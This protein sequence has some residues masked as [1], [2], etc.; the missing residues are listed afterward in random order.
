MPTVSDVTTVKYSGDLRAD[1]LLDEMPDWNYLLPTRTTLF[2]TF[3]VTAMQTVTATAM[4]A[5]NATQRSAATAILNYVT[6]LTGIAFTLT[7]N[8]SAAD[9]HFGSNNLAGATTSGLTRTTESYSFTSGNLLTSYTAE[10]FIYLDN[11]EFAAANN[12]PLAGSQGY[13]VL[14][15]EVGH[16]LGLGHPFDAQFKLSAAEDNT[17]N[18]VMSY[19]AAGGIK[20]TFQSYDVL[21]LQ[22]IYGADGLQGTSGFNSANG[23]S[24]TGGVDALTVTSFSPADEATGVSVGSNILLTFNR[25]IVRGTGSIVL[26]TAAG[27]VVETFDAATS[28]RLSLSGKVLT[29]N[30]TLDLTNSVQYKLEFAAGTIKDASSTS[31]AGTTSY[32]FTA[33]AADV[34]VVDTTAPSISSFTPAVGGTEVATSS[35]ID[36][37]FSESVVKGTGT[38]TL[39]G[40]NGVVVESFDVATS[41]QVTLVGQTLTIDPTA[42]LSRN[43]VYTVE[44]PAGVVRDAAGNVSTAKSGYTFTTVVGD[45]TPPQ[46]LTFSPANA[47]KEVEVFRNIEIGF[48]EAIARGVGTVTLKTSAGA[49]VETFDAATSSRLTIVDSVI[50]ID[51]SADLARNASYTVEI[52]SGAVKDLSGNSFAGALTYGFSTVTGPPPDTTAPLVVQFSPADEATKVLTSANIV[53]TFDEPIQRGQGSIFIQST[54]GLFESYN[55]QSSQSITISGNTLTI[56]PLVDLVKGLDY[57]VIFSQGTVKDLAGNA[58]AGTSTY[59]FKTITEVESDITAPTV[60]SFN[61]AALSKTATVS[62]DIVVTFNESVRLSTNSN[63]ASIVL[64]DAAGT[65]VE[66]FSVASSK[67]LSV[68][69]TKFS[70][71][72]SQDLQPGFTYTL[73][74]PAGTVTDLAGNPFAGSTGHTFTT[75]ATPLALTGTD[76]ANVLVGGGGSDTI[77]ALGGNDTLTGGAGDDLLRGGDG[78]D[79]AVYSGNFSQYTRGF[80]AFGSPT[81]TGLAT[82]DGQDIIRDI[83]RLQFADKKIA[84][85][86]GVNEH[87]GQ[88]LLFLG[89]LAPNLVKAPAAVGTIL[90]FMDQ[91]LSLK[92]V[93]QIALDAGVVTSVAGSNSNAA[94]AAMVLRNLTGVEG[95]ASTVD[96]L[97]SYLD[98]RNASFSQV[99]FLTTIA[100]FELNQTHIGLIGL[101]Q[102]GVEFF[103]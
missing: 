59:N 21:A 33:V 85:D 73:V 31:F 89:M 64:K 6:S 93:F 44:I 78:I 67:G 65:V 39:K 51:P 52:S 66:T 50:T 81:I 103:Q 17:N 38:I 60:Q 22:W 13:E 26:K 12:A 90:G 82:N 68:S 1:S 69:G 35:N 20:T 53:L 3:D 98:G 74:V 37:I 101:Q 11:A 80:N 14:L 54:T 71:N 87:G 76:S 97:V 99:D 84:L 9:F 57:S 45:I 92:D 23:P 4:T 27:V 58:Y 10:A 8:S 63:A 48:T 7:D 49:V 24:L 62:G 72:P 83:E 15:H 56:N 77:D 102:T 29:V 55:A 5:F 88:A 96:L 40:A 75:F 95:D 32:N 61:P 30:P 70:I 25:D 79:T 34:V 18:T 91:N 42:T 2:Y 36:L 100:S 86:L 28:N 46:A 43:T 94:L 47:A 16:A 19:T 41:A